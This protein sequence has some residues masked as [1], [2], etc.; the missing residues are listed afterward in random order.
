MP[1]I[2]D[3]DAWYW[4]ALMDAHSYSFLGKDWV[5]RQQ[6]TK[7]VFFSIGREQMLRRMS[8]DDPDHPDRFALA[9]DVADVAVRAEAAVQR[10]IDDGELVCRGN[11]CCT[12]WMTRKPQPC[13]ESEPPPEP[14]HPPGLRLV[15]RP[16]AP[17]G[18]GERH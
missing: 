13:N 1:T 9:D 3:D 14:T 5:T 7:L 10:A 18:T 17:P 4:E 15:P 16:D 8:L 2:D 6:L 12:D 11:L